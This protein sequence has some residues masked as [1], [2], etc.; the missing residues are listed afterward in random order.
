MNTPQRNLL[1][2]MTACVLHLAA[3]S[4]TDEQ[5]PQTPTEKDKSTQKRTPSVEVAVEETVVEGSFELTGVALKEDYPWEEGGYSF[6]S[7][8]REVK[9]G[10]D[11]PRLLEHSGMPAPFEELEIFAEKW[12]RRTEGG[13]FK[14]ILTYGIPPPPEG[15]FHYRC[16]I[17]LIKGRV[18]DVMLDRGHVS[19]IPGF[20]VVPKFEKK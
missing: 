4:R 18:T 9:K 20:E 14:R 5:T 13:E 8:F 19:V 3:C 11:L 17:T 2:T 16:D 7:H 1:L 10:W 15:G 12:N 6:L